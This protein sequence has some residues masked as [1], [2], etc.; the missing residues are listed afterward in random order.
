MDAAMLRVVRLSLSVVTDRLLTILGLGMT[1]VLACW[2][3]YEP[4]PERLGMAVM[5]A[6]F[7]WLVT[8]KEKKN[9]KVSDGDGA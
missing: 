4:T 7:S 6:V 5:F 3:M 9:E 8:S 2:V 1:F